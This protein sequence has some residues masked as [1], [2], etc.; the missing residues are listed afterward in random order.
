M[1][2]ASMSGS[3]ICQSAASSPT[4]STFTPVGYASATPGAEGAREH[5]G[6]PA[7]AA[8]QNT[9]RA[10]HLARRAKPLTE[11]PPGRSL[12]APPE[13]I[14]RPDGAPAV[15]DRLVLPPRKGRKEGP[16]GRD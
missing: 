1:R 9:A 15:Y 5:R 3:A 14:S 4:N 6:A 13:K 7:A 8:R 11:R 2:P 12:R 10:R 16:H